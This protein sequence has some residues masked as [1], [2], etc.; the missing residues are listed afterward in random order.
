MQNDKV[1]LES[2]MSPSRFSP[3]D[4]HPTPNPT[5][6]ASPSGQ[7]EGDARMPEPLQAGIG[8]YQQDQGSD[9]GS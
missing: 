1:R 8:S 4:H 6:V 3:A 9:V 2:Q 7:D 5:V